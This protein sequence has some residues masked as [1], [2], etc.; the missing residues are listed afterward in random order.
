M[1]ALTATPPPLPVDSS[2]SGPVATIA[3]PPVVVISLAGVPVPGA[4]LSVMLTVAPVDDALMLTGPDESVNV[5]LPLV[6]NC[7]AAVEIASDPIA[8]EPEVADNVPVVSTPAPAIVPDPLAFNVIE[9]ADADPVETLLVSTTPE[10]PAF[11]VSETEPPGVVVPSVIA[12]PTVSTPPEVIPMVPAV[13][14]VI[15]PVLA[16]PVAVTL[17]ALVPSVIVLPV[18]V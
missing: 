8:P 18:F 2:D 11:V 10:L 1:L 15:A 13:V 14:E 5:T 16:V 12:P 9:P 6:L 17:S 3:P 4:K 7:N